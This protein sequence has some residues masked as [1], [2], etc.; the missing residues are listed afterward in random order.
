M[1]WILGPSSYHVTSRRCAL[2]GSISTEGPVGLSQSWSSPSGYFRTTFLCCAAG[3]A[4]CAAAG[5]KLEGTFR[6]ESIEE[7]H[8]VFRLLVMKPLYW[9]S[10]GNIYEWLS[11]YELCMSAA[12]RCAAKFT[13]LT[14][15]WHFAWLQS[16]FLI[17]FFC[18][19]VLRMLLQP[20]VAPL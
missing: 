2:S 12:S 4:L 18:L 8:Q 5:W 19:T 14:A 13:S 15:C 10:T 6:I 1:K 20:L 9:I 16:S 7:S 11:A 3:Y 17:R